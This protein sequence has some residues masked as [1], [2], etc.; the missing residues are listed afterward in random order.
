MNARGHA[1]VWQSVEEALREFQQKEKGVYW[2]PS[3]VVALATVKMLI[4][5]VVLAY[6][7]QADAEDK[8]A[9]G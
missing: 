9:Q 6:T 7:E 4:G 1:K 8:E 3:A 5:H 2:D